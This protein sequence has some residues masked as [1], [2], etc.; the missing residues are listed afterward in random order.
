MKLL[1]VDDHAVLR[2]GLA[3]LL[4]QASPGVEVVQARDVDAALVMI[5]AH[6]DLDIVV[7]DLLMP[8]VGGL[9]ALDRLGRVRPGLPVIVLSSS[10]DP[11]DVRAALGRG[12][13]GY[14]PKSASHHTLLSAVALVLAGELYVPPLM[15]GAAA[16]LEPPQ[17]AT[18]SLTGRQADVLRLLA[19]GRS[20]KAIAAALG[21]SEKTVKV[22]VTAVL[23]ALDAVNRTQAADASRRLGLI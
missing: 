16:A 22:H 12:A 14:V 9:E 21:L 20:N 1:I 2:D 10:E 3:A 5:E 18:P 17:P 11:R 19:E 23:K 4:G 6:P 13:L 7:M 8:G 15:V